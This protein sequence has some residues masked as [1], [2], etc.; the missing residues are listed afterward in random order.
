MSYEAGVL[1]VPKFVSNNDH[2]DLKEDKLVL[3]YDTPLT[4]YE[5]GDTPFFMDLLEEYAAK[6]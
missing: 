6:C 4:N 1:L 3:P 5:D 2:F